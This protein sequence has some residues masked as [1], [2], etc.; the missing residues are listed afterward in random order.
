MERLRELAP[1]V[2]VDWQEGVVDRV[3]DGDT[4]HLVGGTHAVRL[5]GIDAPEHNTPAG[6]RATARLSALLPPGT[7]VIVGLED[8]TFD[9]YDRILGWVV[10]A[11]SSDDDE[12]YGL[13]AEI[14]ARE[15]MA[16]PYRPQKSRAHAYTDRVVRAARQAIVEQRGIWAPGEM[17]PLLLLHR[18]CPPTWERPP[19]AETTP[20]VAPV[21]D[22]QRNAADRTAERT[23]PFEVGR[24][25][26]PAA[27]SRR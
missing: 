4:F 22:Q 10:T 11:P 5:Y 19:I 16:I 20:D 9:P 15:G 25:P 18:A 27:M 24:E 14:L 2:L 23:D 8:R 17:G 26:E 7:P 13:V 21:V 12:D 6:V 3:V 1:D